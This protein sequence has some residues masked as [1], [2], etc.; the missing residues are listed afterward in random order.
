VNQLVVF[1]LFVALGKTVLLIGNKSKKEV[2]D[3]EL[4][5]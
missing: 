4:I 2:M 1:S 5:L 3:K